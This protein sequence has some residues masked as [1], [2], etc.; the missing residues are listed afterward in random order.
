MPGT[1]KPYK[2]VA[3]KDWPHKILVGFQDFMSVKNHPCLSSAYG[4]RSLGDLAKEIVENNKILCSLDLWFFGSSQRTK[5]KP[6]PANTWVAFD[7]QLPVMISEGTIIL[8]NMQ[9]QV[10]ETIQVKEYI[11]QEILDIRSLQNGIYM[12]IFKAGDQSKSGK[13][14][15]R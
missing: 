10:I 15:V 3:F 1:G 14:I 2:C 12:Y 13:L 4:G 8:M 7:Y 9:G 11:G 5:R 6:N